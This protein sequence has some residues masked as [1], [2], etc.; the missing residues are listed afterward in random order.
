MPRKSRKKSSSSTTPKTASAPLRSD[1]T[2]YVNCFWRTRLTLRGDF[3]YT[4][5]TS[6]LLALPPKCTF[7]AFMLMSKGVDVL[8]LHSFGSLTSEDVKWIVSLKNVGSSVSE[9]VELAKMTSELL[10][11]R[12]PLERAFA[13]SGLKSLLGKCVELKE[14][15]P[16]STSAPSS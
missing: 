1:H 5:S 13:A 8:D 2:I 15:S 12:T 10:F 16:P 9:L 11:G 7:E 3:S 14:A 4:V 6:G